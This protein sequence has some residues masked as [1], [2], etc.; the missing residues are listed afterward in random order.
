M[1]KSPHENGDSLY[2]DSLAHTEIW[3]EV[4]YLEELYLLE[5]LLRETED[6]L[7]HNSFRLRENRALHI[8]TDVKQLLMT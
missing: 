1:E 6:F 3:M 2:S 4:N 7:S 5:N 8:L